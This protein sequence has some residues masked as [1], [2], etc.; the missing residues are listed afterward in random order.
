MIELIS[1]Q[2]IEKFKDT[3]F[4]PRRSTRLQ[5]IHLLPIHILSVE[6]QIH[7]LLGRERLGVEDLGDSPS[8][9]RAIGDLIGDQHGAIILK[10]DVS[11]IEEEVNMRSKH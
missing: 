11:L 9:E 8:P 10:R 4:L 7:R 1:C 3:S 5:S 6:L 2:E